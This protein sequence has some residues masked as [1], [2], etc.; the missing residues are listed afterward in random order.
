VVGRWG[1]TFSKILR[2][3]ALAVLFGG[4]A[5]IVFA[6]ITLVK[7]AQAQGVPVAEAANAN[8]PLFIQFSKVA[9]G[10]GIALLL[11]ECLDFAANR[12]TDKLTIARYVSSLLCVATTMIFAFGIVPVMEELRPRIK[13]D[14]TAHAEF[15]K[16]HEVSRMVFASTIFLA[17]ISLVIPALGPEAALTKA[18]KSESA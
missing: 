2:L 17:L 10:A 13:T 6:A 5:A 8:A 12:L 9:L 16:L 1:K 18:Q 11:A 4:S 7:A 15:H 14:E 3:V